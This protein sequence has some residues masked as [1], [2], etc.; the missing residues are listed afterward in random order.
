MTKN[1]HND[2]KLKNILRWKQQCIIYLC[3][4]KPFWNINKK[5]LYTYLSHTASA[6]RDNVEGKYNTVYQYSSNYWNDNNNNNNNNNNNDDND[7]NND[8]DND[9]NSGLIKLLKPVKYFW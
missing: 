8:N 5:H 9:N 2:K 6:A 7:N 1:F 3:S 4:E